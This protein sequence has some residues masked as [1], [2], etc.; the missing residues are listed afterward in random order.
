MSLRTSLS[1]YVTGACVS[2]LLA[3]ELRKERSAHIIIT[4]VT[5]TKV[6]QQYRPNAVKN[7]S[8]PCGKTTQGLQVVASRLLLGRLK[9]GGDTIGIVWV[10]L[11]FE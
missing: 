2:G 8:R 3:P 9:E 4:Q 10:V 1:S 5:L 6:K 7:D 11:C